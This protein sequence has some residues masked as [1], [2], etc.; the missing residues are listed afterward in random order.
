MTRAAGL[1]LT[2]GLVAAA[3][4][5]ELSFQE[6]TVGAGLL[7]KRD[8]LDFPFANMTGGATVGDFNRDGWQDLFLLGGGRAPDAL[9][10]NNGDG[11]FT[12]HAAAAGLAAYHRGIAVAVGDYDANGWLDLFVTSLGPADGPP[13][14]RQHRL[15]HNAGT[16]DRGAHPPDAAAD[17]RESAAGIPDG[18]AD[19]RDGAADTPDDGAHPRDGGP[20]AGAG[21]VKL[22][23]ARAVPTFRE[24]AAAVGVA[25][26][27]TARADA[28]GAAF[29]DYDL[30]G[31]LDL[32]V[33]AYAEA[34]GN[35]LYRNLGREPPRF[36]DATA[37]IAADLTIW[38]FAPAFVDLDGDRYPELLIAA[39]FGTS[40]YLRNGGAGSHDGPGALVDA[41]AASGTDREA[42]GMGSAIGDFNNDGL[43]DW[44]LTS[45]Y[46]DGG[47]VSKVN[48]NLLYV[49][50]GGHR[51]RELSAAAGVDNGGWGWGAVA[52][53]L[54]HDGLLDIVATNGWDK[55]NPDGIPEWRSEP[56]HVF[57]NRGDLAFHHAT[58]EVGLVHRKHGR[59]LLHFDYD[60]DGDQ[61]LLI[62]NQQG[63]VSLYRNDLSGPGTNWLRVF[64]DTRGAPHLAP[65]GFGTRV[66]VL[67][68]G[69]WQAR[70]IYGGS[71]FSGVPE[72]SAHFGLGAAATVDLLRVTWA[73]GRVTER[74]GLAPNQTIVV[75]PDALP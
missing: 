31:D 65:D 28:M 60:N 42:N 53:D 15:Y 36:A 39:D 4:G 24:V 70:A 2:L 9:Y 12:D 33:T 45:V 69:R 40:R 52:V 23:A 49:N 32:F 66:A 56:T 6:A 13:R 10:L 74:S 11:T 5:A 22:G 67:A 41:T 25:G 19:T 73:D 17:A 44:Y 47:S 21:A 37:T 55:P 59:G 63:P 58:F 68:G 64:A 48:G 27:L 61:D 16:G 7:A 8:P 29:G 54:D 14:I 50:Q 57:L 20:P 35:R 34:Q 71:T 62:V 26:P 1:L 46:A 18:R 30:D 75:Q 3:A 72:L 43:L 38:A 51:Y